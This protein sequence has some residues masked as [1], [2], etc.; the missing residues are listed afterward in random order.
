MRGVALLKVVSAAALL[1]QA[2]A[3]SLKELLS[4]PFAGTEPSADRMPTPP[5]AAAA[6]ATPRKKGRC[7]NQ[8]RE[9]EVDDDCNFKKAWRAAYGIGTCQGGEGRRRRR[10]KR[11]P[12]PVALNAP[13][14]S[15]TPRPT[16][17]PTV[18]AAERKAAATRRCAAS[19]RRPVVDAGALDVL[20][21]VPGLLDAGRVQVARRNWAML[22]PR[23][24]IVPTWQRCGDDPDLDEA[25]DG[26]IDGEEDGPRLPYL[27]EACDVPRVPTKGTGGYVAQ[28]KFVLPAHVQALG[29][30][31]VFV[32]L[33]DV[34]LF[35]G[36]FD[37]VPFFRIAARNALD[38]ASPA[39]RRAHSRRF[40]EMRPRHAELTNGAVG[41]RVAKV[42]LF[43]T[44]FTRD[45]YHCFHDLA[46]V[47]M[48]AEGYGYPDWLPG[49]CS[50]RGEKFAAGV[51]DV[52]RAS[53][54]LPGRRDAWAKSY[55]DSAASR[56]RKEMAKWYAT[57]GVQ[58]VR[59]SRNV[60]GFLYDSD[61]RAS[62]S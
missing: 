54:G 9:C 51:V 19:A 61:D 49:Y 38:V 58:L 56:A 14:P 48:N 12:A 11:T 42:E 15:P 39:I 7:T 32:V 2:G 34:R 13:T 22:R 28:L 10:T 55:S 4:A 16:P 27:S 8:D 43:A 26:P 50:L 62:S 18:D 52:F 53:H 6:P 29:V 25:I 57:R 60:T 21:V 41:R 36:E 44:A 1:L 45:A 20:L 40:P 24:C 35:A 33:D 37:A 47:E 23:A 30:R 3:Q 46:D 59:A 31:W 5:D 17:R